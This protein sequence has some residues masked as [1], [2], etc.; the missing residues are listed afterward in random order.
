MRRA[1]RGA[2]Q[3]ASAY[4]SHVDRRDLLL[5]QQLRAVHDDNAPEV[6]FLDAVRALVRRALGLGEAHKRLDEELAGEA[7]LAVLGDPAE[8]DGGRHARL[9]RRKLR[10]GKELRGGGVDERLPWVLVKAL[11]AAVEGDGRLLVGLG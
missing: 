2:P 1:E 9:D 8:D 5:I 7:L 4:L 3:N 10:G 6:P 11:D